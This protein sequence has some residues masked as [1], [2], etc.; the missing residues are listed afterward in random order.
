MEKGTHNIANPCNCP[1][2]PPQGCWC[3][4]VWWSSTS[5]SWP[6]WPATTRFRSTTSSPG[7]CRASAVQGL[8]SLLAGSSSCCWHCPTAPG[9]GVS[10]RSTAAAS[11]SLWSCRTLSAPSDCEEGGYR[12]GKRVGV[13]KNVWAKTCPS[14][15]ITIFLLILKSFFNVSH[16]NPWRLINSLW[17]ITIIWLNIV[18]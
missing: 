18:V 15:F 2:S 6:Y 8:S 17:L 12:G 9:R 11:G 7:R 13:P 3:F 10:L 16:L 4:S 5:L 14:S 1:L